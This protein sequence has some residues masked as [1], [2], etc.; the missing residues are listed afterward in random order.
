MTQQT[1]NAL[2]RKTGVS[3]PYKLD[4]EK[5]YVKGHKTVGEHVESVFEWVRT[6]ADEG[7]RIDIVVVGDSI[8]EVARY[9]ETR[10]GEWKTKVEAVAVGRLVFSDLLGSYLT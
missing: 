8:E 3:S 10:W 5:N 7:A 1:W 4:P 6:E 9:L 2:P